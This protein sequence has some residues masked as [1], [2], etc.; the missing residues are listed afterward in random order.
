MVKHATGSGDHHMRAA[1][2]RDG[3]SMKVLASVDRGDRDPKSAAITMKCF[4]NLHREFAGGDKHKKKRLVRSRLGSADPLQQ[5]KRECCGLPSTSRGLAEDVL[6]LE[7]RRSGS[8]LNRRGF[9]VSK[10]RELGQQFWPE[11]ELCKS[12]L[13]PHRIPDTVIACLRWRTRMSNRA[14]SCARKYLMQP[15]S[16]AKSGHNHR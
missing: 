7:Q 14:E 3:L 9:F 2:Q 16:R 8:L 5:R 11:T 6:S 10:R 4:R 1:A 13:H 15:K 12:V